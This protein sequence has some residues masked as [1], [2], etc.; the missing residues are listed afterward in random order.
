MP[1]PLGKTLLRQFEKARHYKPDLTYTTFALANGYPPHVVA[2]RIGE[3]LELR[4]KQ[5]PFSL[6]E[7]LKL[8]GDWMIAGDLHIPFTSLE[9]VSLLLQVARAQDID[10]LLLTGDIFNADAFSNY[11]HLTDKIPTWAQ[12]RDMLREL[13]QQFRGRFKK[14]V[15][16][17]GNHERR[18]QKMTIGAFD[19][20]DIWALVTTAE[21]LI[22]TPFGYCTVNDTWRVTHPKNYSINQLTVG[23]VLAQKYES[24]VI[25][26]HEHHLSMG[27]DRYGRYVVVNGGCLVDPDK[28]AY[29]SLDDNKAAV[30]KNGF[31]MLR[32]NT[33]YLFGKEPMTDWSRWI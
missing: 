2:A 31:V 17:M 4:E 22:T 33:P 18:I 28:L 10:Q 5:P 29:V 9:W 7:P 8:A 13:F 1:L 15:A 32:N 25:T 12:E 19:E 6:G 14:I 30:M 11:P 26:F 24:H 20:V 16:L 21:N 3:V 23:D 27:W